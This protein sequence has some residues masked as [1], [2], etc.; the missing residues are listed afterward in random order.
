MWRQRCTYWRCHRNIIYPEEEYV[1][2]NQDSINRDCEIGI[3]FPEFHNQSSLTPLIGELGSHQTF[4]V[5]KFHLTP[6]IHG[7]GNGGELG[8]NGGL[9]LPSCVTG[10]QTV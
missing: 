5:K 9:P 4:H 6:L 1:F 7:A 10:N 8:N 3:L 2:G